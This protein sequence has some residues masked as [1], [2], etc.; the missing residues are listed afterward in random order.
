MAFT[1][2]CKAALLR[3]EGHPLIIETITVDPPQG[4]E[5]RVRVVSAGVCATDGHPVWGRETDV[6]LDTGGRPMVLG[7]EGAGVVESTGPAVTSVRPG[8]KVVIMWMPECGRCEL[9][10]NP[11]T[12]HCLSGNIVTNMY[13]EG[14]QCRTHVDGQPVLMFFGTGTFAQYTVVR[15]AQVAKVNP[16]ANLNDICIIGCAVGTGYAGA[17]NIA[18]VQR[19][20]KC[21]VWGLGAIGLSTVLG[22]RDAGAAQIIGIDRNDYKGEIAK[23]LGC[24]RFINPKTTDKQIDD[25]LKSEGGVD[26]A[27]DCIG[28]VDVIDSCLKSLHPWGLPP[29]GKTVNIPSSQ[30]LGGAHVS[31]GYY[32]NAKPRALNQHLVDLHCTDRLPIEHMI[33]QR[34]NLD[35]INK[36]FDDLKAGKAI[37]TVIVFD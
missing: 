3:T 9:C 17:T 27:F 14:G 33:T 26:Y 25:I 1:I 7:H 36:A 10:A 20:S 35:D 19:G 23:Q 31:G 24:T 22:C 15:E 8:D 34:L 37:R 11:R 21:V 6:Q 18:K 29:R 12:N 32:G 30:L 5:V 13:H 4:S 16:K 2:T 28:S